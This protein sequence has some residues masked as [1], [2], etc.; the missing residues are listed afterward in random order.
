MKENWVD[1]QRVFLH[2]KIYHLSR[3][4]LQN[5]NIVFLFIL[6]H[7]DTWRIHKNVSCSA[8]GDNQIYIYS[9]GLS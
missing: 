1:C 7:T 3:P 6:E 5:R 2:L 4:S 8:I 9:N